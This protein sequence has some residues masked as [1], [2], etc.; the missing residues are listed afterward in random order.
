[1]RQ[2]SGFDLIL[3]GYSTPRSLSR[4]AYEFKA[5][6]ALALQNSLGGVDLQTGAATW[7]QGDSSKTFGSQFRLVMPFTIEGQL[8]DLGSVSVTLS[9]TEG[10]STPAAANFP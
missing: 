8:G 5:R 7:F 1:L 9:N 4:I 3:N 2:P 6:G 10:N